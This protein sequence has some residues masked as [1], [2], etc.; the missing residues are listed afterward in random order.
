MHG[1]RFA[2]AS[3]SCHKVVFDTI[4][5][6]VVV[7]DILCWFS[8]GGQDQVGISLSAAIDVLGRR[9]YF[10]SW[11]LGRW[12]CFLVFPF[13]SSER[14][15]VDWSHSHSWLLEQNIRIV[16][17]AD[18]IWASH[19]AA[20]QFRLDIRT[21]SF[22]VASEWVL[23]ALDFL[24]EGIIW[25]VYQLALCAPIALFSQ[26]NTLNSVGHHLTQL[27]VLVNCVL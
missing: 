3:L 26:K 6:L 13:A 1:N 15:P 4:S 7:R 9:T 20:H 18:L 25:G 12:L 11:Y 23:F 24:R 2:P 14:S 27:S 22:Y 8:L 19:W 16:Y 17:L 10:V 5:V 21:F